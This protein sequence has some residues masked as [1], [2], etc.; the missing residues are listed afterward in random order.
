[1][2]ST[3]VRRIGR[4]SQVLTASIFLLAF[5][6]S[7]TLVS[8]QEGENQAGLVIQFGDGSLF[9]TCV[10][11]GPDGEA[12]GEEL[13]RASGLDSIIDYGSGF[14]GGTVCK[15]DAEGCDFPTEKCFCQCTMKPGDPCVYWSYFY[16]LDGQW[17]YA[18][19]GVSAFIVKS[20][21]VQGWAWGEGAVGTGIRPPLLTFE[22]I[23]GPALD[24]THTPTAAVVA[25]PTASLLPSDTPVQDTPSPSPGSPTV[26]SAAIVS[27]SPTEEL[28]LA[29]QTPTP[30]TVVSTVKEQP[31]STPGESGSESVNLIIFGVLV[32]VLL[33]GLIVLGVRRGQ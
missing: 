12:T 1:M 22:Q 13:L 32:A 14:G 29:L 3:Q 31:S 19:Q 15:I 8:A 30:E 28:T 5:F 17:R 18:S 26:E 33:G 24:P 10:E 2:Q 21:D 27:A 9:T 4:Q 25:S 23:C 7:I 11:L 6:S 16:L 20:G